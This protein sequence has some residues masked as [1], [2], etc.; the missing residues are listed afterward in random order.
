MWKLKLIIVK[1]ISQ[2][3]MKVWNHKCWNNKGKIYLA[4]YW[5]WKMK[6][7][8][9]F[10]I[11]C[12]CEKQAETSSDMYSIRIYKTSCSL[13]QLRRNVRKIMHRLESSHVYACPEIPCAFICI[14]FH[15]KR[16][17]NYGIIIQF[18]YKIRHKLVELLGAKTI[19]IVVYGHPFA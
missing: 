9:F 10:D 11:L 7:E 16:M 1:C 13:L 3:L 17:W 5:I 12:Q 14:H 8:I 18:P 15:S 6:L 4:N 2:F 19:L